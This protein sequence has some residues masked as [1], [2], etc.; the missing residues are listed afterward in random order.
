MPSQSVLFA[1]IA[2]NVSKKSLDGS[3]W[4]W[5]NLLCARDTQE[6]Y[7]MKADVDVVVVV[8]VVVPEQFRIHAEGTSE[9]GPTGAP[10]RGKRTR[11][12]GPRH[13]VKL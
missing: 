6:E 1:V 11:R 12:I 4:V 5:P 8:V 7:E 9:A 3:N 2:I 10:E 13:A